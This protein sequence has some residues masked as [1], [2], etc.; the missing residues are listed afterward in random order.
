MPLRRRCTVEHAVF[1]QYATDGR[2]LIRV[3]AREGDTLHFEDAT[4]ELNDPP[5]AMPVKE[6]V[7]KFRVVKQEKS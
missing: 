6:F 4:D 3:L 7:R 1:E 2:H 5:R